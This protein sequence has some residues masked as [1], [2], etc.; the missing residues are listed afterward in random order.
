MLKLCFSKH[1]TVKLCVSIGI[2]SRIS[3]SGLIYLSPS[4]SKQDI[5]DHHQTHSIFKPLFFSSTPWLGSV[6]PPAILFSNN[7]LLNRTIDMPF[8]QPAIHRLSNSLPLDQTRHITGVDWLARSLSLAGS[9]YHVSCNTG[10]LTVTHIE[11]HDTVASGR[12]F[13]FLGLALPETFERCGRPNEGDR[14]DAP[15]GFINLPIFYFFIYSSTIKHSLSVKLWVS[16]GLKCTYS[17]T[18]GLTNY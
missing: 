8:L 2:V 15:M 1:I 16:L 7:L 10:M 13:K 5:F 18:N 4:Y 9:S 17:I 11:A 3:T 14:L 6:F 12:I